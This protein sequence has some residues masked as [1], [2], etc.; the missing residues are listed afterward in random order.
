[1]F[2]KL[3]APVPQSCSVKQSSTDRVGY[4]LASRRGLECGLEAVE[5]DASASLKLF[6]AQELSSLEA[7]VWRYAKGVVAH[8]MHMTST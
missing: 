4:C 7:G 2:G 8:L 1:M 6:F 3:H 5:A